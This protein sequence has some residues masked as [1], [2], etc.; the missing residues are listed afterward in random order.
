MIAIDLS[1]SH[2]LTDGESYPMTLVDSTVPILK[3]QALWSNQDG[4]RL[5]LYGGRGASKTQS[6]DGIWE[7]YT[8]DTTWHR[9]SVGTRPIR[10]AGGGRNTDVLVMTETRLIKR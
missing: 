9:Q 5:F 3:D 2:D 4:S 8:T 10:L 6:D 7:Y 1:E